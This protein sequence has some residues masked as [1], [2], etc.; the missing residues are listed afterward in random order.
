MAK[1]DTPLL[2][3]LEKGKWPSFVKDMKQA[4]QKKVMAK[5]LLRQLEQTMELLLQRQTYARFLF[6]VILLLGICVM[7][8]HWLAGQAG[9]GAGN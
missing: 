3:D 5:D 9:C 6:M 1:S 4:A 8:N 7:V 2:D